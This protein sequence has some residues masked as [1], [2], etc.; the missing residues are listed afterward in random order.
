MA[1]KMATAHPSVFANNTQGSDVSK[2]SPGIKQNLGQ[3]IARKFQDVSGDN[4]I[5]ETY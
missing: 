4:E 5:W 1:T 2:E 3:G